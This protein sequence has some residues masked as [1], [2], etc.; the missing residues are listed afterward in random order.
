S[1]DLCQKLEAAGFSRSK[2][3]FVFWEGV[4]YY[5]E[6]MAVHGTLSKLARLL[7]PGSQVVFDYWNREIRL[8]RMA[9]V[10]WGRQALMTGGLRLLGE[11]LKS[12]FT[13]S[14]LNLALSTHGFRAVEHFDSRWMRE[15]YIPWREKRQLFHEMPVVLAERC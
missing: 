3:T 12:S 6:K 9:P 2:K 14:Q 10:L 13:K 7:S 8:T 15:K 5:L 1:E 4:T 11:A